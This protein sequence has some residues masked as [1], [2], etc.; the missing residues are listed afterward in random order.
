MPFELSRFATDA[1][2]NN[3]VVQAGRVGLGALVRSEPFQHLRNAALDRTSLGL[4]EKTFIKAMTGGDKVTPGGIELSDDQLA[5]LKQAY[6][7]QKDPSRRPRVREFDPNREQFAGMSPEELEIERQWYNENIR[8]YDND[9]LAKFNSPYVST[10]GNSPKMSGYGRDLKM[11]LGGLSMTNTPDGMRIQDTW[12]IDPAS[13][14]AKDA[15]T[16]I[17][18][19]DKDRP[20][21]VVDLK[22]GGNVP[23]LI[24]N[25]A[26][27]LNT[28]EPIEI[29]QTIPANTWNSITPREASFEERVAGNQGAGLQTLNNLYSNLFKRQ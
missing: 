11:T 16:G 20:D 10:Y 1:I 27:A 15:S 13:E 23:S 7:D 3:P 4:P 24:A 2:A 14:V 8:K 29:D 6:T 12:D 19:R 5:R 26:R 21:L 22:E 28:Y 25:A 9:A 17:T 18:E